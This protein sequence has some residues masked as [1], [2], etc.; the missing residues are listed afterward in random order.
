MAGA[1]TITFNGDNFDDE[2]IG[3]S[4]PVLVDFWAEW[5]QPCKALGPVIDAIADDYEGRVKVGKVD[6]DSNQAMTVKFNITSIPTVVIFQD[7]EIKER[8]VGSRS[9]EDFAEA[10]DRI[11]AG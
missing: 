7:G 1:N 3:S 2:V 4:A 5:C 9:K 6:I 8:F 10:L 11:V